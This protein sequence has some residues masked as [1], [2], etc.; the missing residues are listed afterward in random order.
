MKHTATCSRNSRYLKLFW[1]NNFEMW[2]RLS[3]GEMH[4]PLVDR[5]REEYFYAIKRGLYVFLEQKN[6]RK[7]Q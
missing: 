1:L 4:F 5:E 3:A 2:E 6:Y 7:C